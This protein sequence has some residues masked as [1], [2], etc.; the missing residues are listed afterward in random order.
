MSRW[1][2]PLCFVVVF[3]VT[4]LALFS[5]TPSP[6]PAPRTSPVATAP[7]VAQLEPFSYDCP[8]YCVEW[9]DLETTP[10]EW[11][12]V[13]A[14]SDIDTAVPRT[15]AGLSL[16]PDDQ[17]A[18]NYCRTDRHYRNSGYE[19]G[20][21]RADSLS[22]GSEHHRFA[23]YW[24]NITPMLPEFNRGLYRQFELLVQRTATEFGTASVCVESVCKDDMQDCAAGWSVPSHYRVS[25]GWLA[26]DGDHVVTYLLPQR[27]D[28]IDLED[29][30]VKP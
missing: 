17:Q 25:L 8:L 20:H 19:R 7:S 6:A 18:W 23:N 21:V 11:S 29:C 3:A 24:P 26:T 28:G 30:E 4:L 16:P 12:F 5:S 10:S 9:P 27:C 1:S 15:D 22:D 2:L 13:V 14:A